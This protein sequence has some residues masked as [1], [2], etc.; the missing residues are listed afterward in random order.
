MTATRKLLADYTEKGSETAFRDLVARY[1]DLV[2]STALRSVDGDTHLAQDVAQTVFIDLARL[3]GTLSPDSMLGGWLHRHTCYTAAKILRGERRR[4]LRERQA[5]EM[6]TP[7]DSADATLAHVAPILDDAINQL[8]RLDRTAILLRFFERQDLRS[9][10]AALGSNEDAARKRVAR[11][12]DKLHVLLKRRGV[13]LSAATLGTALASEAV[14]A[15]PAG[16]SLTLSSTALAAGASFAGANTLTL[17]KF[18][19]MTKLKTGLLSTMVVASAVTSLVIQH[20]AQASLSGLQQSRRHQSDQAAQL[21][22]ET[23]SLSARLTHASSGDPNGQMADLLKLRTEAAGLRSLTNQ[24]AKLAQKNPRPPQPAS[25][26]NSPLPL[27]QEAFD[28]M[29]FSKQMMLAFHQYAEGHGGQFPTNFEQAASFLGDPAQD[30]RKLTSTQFEIMY[31]G[32]PSAL[33]NTSQIIVLREKQAV[34]TPD[35]GWIRAYAFADGHS[36]IHKEPEGRFEAWEQ[37]HLITPS[38]P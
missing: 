38:T 1:V 14:A 10:G 9:V 37:Q 2:Y 35:G 11:A 25:D 6:N 13:A 3:A 30:G 27:T 4:R 29:N 16:L 31:Q 36:E 15:A 8:G 22:A 7:S 28:K 26:P 20:R 17:L 33:T 23:D 32:S 19:T 18:I 5:A 21:R 24:I 12:L 34:Q